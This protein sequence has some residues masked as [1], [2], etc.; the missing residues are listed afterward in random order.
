MLSS[1]ASR[2]PKIPDKKTKGKIPNGTTKKKEKSL[3]NGIKSYHTE[4]SA[5]NFLEIS[6]MDL[7]YNPT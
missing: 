3:R 6:Y 7:V 5:S 4:F 2:N 1:L